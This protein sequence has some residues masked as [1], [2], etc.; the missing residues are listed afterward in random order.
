MASVSTD[1]RESDDDTTTLGHATVPISTPA[2]KTLTRTASSFLRSSSSSMQTPSKSDPPQSN[3]PGLVGGGGGL[4][5]P[6][7]IA[8][9]RFLLA[10]ANDAYRVS[11]LHVDAIVCMEQSSH[12]T[13]N[14]DPYTTSGGVSG[15]G[16]AHE[17]ARTVSDAFQAVTE[18][19]LK[20]V[21]RVVFAPL[22]QPV[23]IDFE[24]QWTEVVYQ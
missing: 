14:N 18:A 2:T 19:A 5:S 22:V 7:M 10:C 11:T 20:G 16:V 6:E 24:T 1:N 3:G 23:L 21:V 15:G 13:N 17:V 12:E 4:D 9:L 8:N